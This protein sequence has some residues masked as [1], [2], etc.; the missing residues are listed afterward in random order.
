[1]AWGPVARQSKLL[2]PFRC[3]GRAAGVSLRIDFDS[4][5][6]CLDAPAI[7]L[8]NSVAVPETLRLRGCKVSFT[9]VRNRLIFI[10]IMASESFRPISKSGE[11]RNHDIGQIW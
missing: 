10:Y 9:G 6:V 1:M 2:S 3:E 11:L 8:C 5:A 7:R 4:P